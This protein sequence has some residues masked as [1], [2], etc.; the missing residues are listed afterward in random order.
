MVS[1]AV[2]SAPHRTTCEVELSNGEIFKSLSY[3]RASITICGE[4]DR[5]VI[6]ALS[7]IANGYRKS[8]K[9]YGIVNVRKLTE[10]ERLEL[11]AAQVIKPR[12][13][14]G[15]KTQALRD[16]M[17]LARSERIRVRI[18]LVS[19][20]TIEAESIQDAARQITG[21]NSLSRRTAA[22]AAAIGNIIKG[23]QRK[24]PKHGILAVEVLN[25]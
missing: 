10:A 3:S 9:K 21:E 4:K 5:R 17:M 14:R 24:S 13:P 8:S 2:M 23:W 19:G 25:D 1:R 6:N 11:D 18:T 16:K 20:E 7:A 22:C 15:P 12:Q